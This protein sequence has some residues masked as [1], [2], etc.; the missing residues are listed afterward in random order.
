[1][2]R[3][4][5]LFERDGTAEPAPQ[6]SEHVTYL[7]P[8]PPI[9]DDEELPAIGRILVILRRR[10]A[11]F[12]V[13]ALGVLAL[14]VVMTLFIPRRYESSAAFLIETRSSGPSSTPALAVL[15][16]L[17]QANNVETELQ[18]LTSRRVVAD[19]VRDLGLNVKIEKVADR[20][21]KNWDDL[22][23]EA[24]SAA[25]PGAYVVEFAGDNWVVR[26]AATGE[27]F[28]HR[29]GSW[30]LAEGG[31]GLAVHFAGM[32]LRV[33]R[34]PLPDRTVVEIR[35][36]DEVV[37]GVRRNISAEPL[38]RD[39]NVVRLTCK[40]GSPSKARD[41]CRSISD[42]YLGLRLDLQ[43]GE[44]SAAA[45]FLGEQVDQVKSRLAIAED[46]LQ[47]YAVRNQAVALDERARIEVTQNAELTAHL[48]LLGA[49]RN[50]ISMLLQRIETGDPGS[51]KYRDLASFPTFVRSDRSVVSQL[52]ETLVGLENRRSELALTR[53]ETNPDLRAVDARI[54]EIEIQLRSIASSYEQSLAVQIESLDGALGSSRAKLS[55]IPRRQVESARLERQVLM[56]EELYKFLDTRLREAEIARAVRLPSVRIV[57]TATLPYRASYPRTK[58]N[59]AI[60]MILALVVGGGVVGYQEHR[61]TSLRQPREVADRAGVPVLTMVPHLEARRVLGVEATNGKRASK[62]SDLAR[63][64]E[65]AA[66][67][68]LFEAFRTLSVELAFA[69]ERIEGRGIRSLCV[70]SSTRGEGKTTTACNLAIV[71]ALQG[72]R[73]L[74]IDTDLRGSQVG[75]CFGVPRTAPTLAAVLSEGSWSSASGQIHEQS[76]GNG[77][78]LHVLPS[79]DFSRSGSELL[80]SDALRDL[81][82]TVTK[83]YEFVVVDTPPLNV[84]TDAAPIAGWVDSVI[85]VVRAG[86]TDPTGLDLTLERLR[87][88]GAEVTGVVL[89]DLALPEY[90]A[91]YSRET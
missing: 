4:P 55:S 13:S 26:D 78:V 71:R 42:A 82:D 2:P 57:D 18:L 34:P 27:P 28:E 85:V 60:G 43:Q 62:R 53:T 69:G 20:D 91:S 41:M 5:E 56:L 33:R 72:A 15:E 21:N 73:T 54:E 81:L 88:A 64:N 37:D 65:A 22:E 48:E 84:L 39:A 89:N 83:A 7:V 1:M 46:S 52:V 79:G 86:H 51:R 58:L 44:A 90:Y 68:V 76:L 25:E 3:Y 19:A 23:V 80:V 24:T 38:D 36:F 29:V 11:A 40:A 17:G 87:R 45:E 77:K 12:L 14:V 67:E 70:T 6:R 49:E 50:A 32:T 31:T 75:R 61:D 63:T 16:R 10:R 59:L 8:A 74:L 9:G 35:P 66:E 47:S 30:S